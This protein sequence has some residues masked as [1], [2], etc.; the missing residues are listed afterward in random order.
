MMVKTSSAAFEDIR[1]PV[2]YKLVALW[3][4][5]VFLYIYGDYFELYQ[6]G[7]LQAMIAGKTGLGAVTQTSLMGM[8]AMM[9]VPGL[10]V[11]LSL[12][13]PA[14]VNRWVNIILGTVYAAIM[15]LAVQGSWHFYTLYGL[16]E[17]ALTLSI[18]WCAWAWPKQSVS[19]V[20]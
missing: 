16:I 4:S 2:R 14:P 19:S 15:V 11:F 20:S 1:V 7:K 17:I 3:S 13:L 18:A 10:M 9:A 8:A 5:V 6:P 12:V